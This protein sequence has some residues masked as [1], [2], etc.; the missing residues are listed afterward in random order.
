MGGGP[1]HRG[2]SR[3]VV[4]VRVVEEVRDGEARQAEGR[5]FGRL[6]GLCAFGMIHL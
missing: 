3:R 2:E 1:E 6:L 5:G 4:L